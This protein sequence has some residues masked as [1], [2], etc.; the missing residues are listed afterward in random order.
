M[1]PQQRI[2]LEV[3]E[4]L[5]S[6]GIRPRALAGTRA[7]VFVGL[8]NSDYSRH[9][10]ADWSRIDA[11]YATG[12]SS[13][14]AAN[15]ISYLLDLHGPSLA[16]DTACSSSLVALHQAI[17]SI[18]QGECNLAIVGGV[19]LILS[20]EVTIN[21]SKAGVMAKDGRC[22]SFSAE[23][24]GYGRGEGAGVVVIKPLSLAQAD[25]DPIL[26]IILGSAVNNDGRSNGLMAPNGEAQK[27]VLREA[28]RQAG[29]SPGQVQYVE[30]HGTGTAQ[31]SHRG[32]CPLTSLPSAPPTTLRPR[33][34]KSKHWSPGIRGRNCRPH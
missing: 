3:V 29:V 26:G 27:Q 32:G 17:Q 10:F 23:A 5:E 19:S 15:R 18:R 16:V 8:S 21:F 34:G 22:K 11:Y 28:C 31:R 14:I 6:A 33:R 13:A 25:N 2:L 9:L 7:G 1:D 20:P 12:I 24:D 30:T 4:A